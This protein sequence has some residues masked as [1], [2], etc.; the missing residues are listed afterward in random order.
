MNVFNSRIRILLL[1]ARNPGDPAK[2]EEVRSFAERTAVA[3]EQIVGWDL[4]QG[5]PTLAQVRRHDALMVGGSGEFFVSKRDLPDH[6]RS[7]DLLLEVVDRGYP[8]FA[9]CFGFQCLVQALGGEVVYD[10]DN[11]EVGTFELTLTED[12]R[13]DELFGHLPD[14]FLAQ[15]GH[16]DRAAGPVGGLPTLAFSD[17]APVQ[18][19]RIPGKPI[20]ATQFHPEL[21]RD[22]NLG[23]YE[24]YLDSYAATLNPEE[25]RESLK[26]FRESPATLDLLARFVRLVFG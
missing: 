2:D 17:R 9:S 16:K 20:W 24:R 12:G 3:A 6:Q 10:P 8:T 11:T 22:T 26:S 4:L 25:L 7:L 18:A 14:R 19:L 1:Q 21:A 15:L 5:P 13:R 23:R